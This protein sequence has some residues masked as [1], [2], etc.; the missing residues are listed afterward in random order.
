MTLTRRFAN[1]DYL[2]LGISQNKYSLLYPKAMSIVTTT[3]I[4]YRWK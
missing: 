4:F 3:R 2:E 1:N